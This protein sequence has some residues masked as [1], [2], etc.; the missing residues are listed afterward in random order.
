MGN[1]FRQTVAGIFSNASVIPDMMLEGH[2]ANTLA[3]AEI[4][5]DS[6]TRYYVLQWSYPNGR[7]GGDTR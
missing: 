5:L 1:S 3:R 7:F 4:L 2:I 6:G